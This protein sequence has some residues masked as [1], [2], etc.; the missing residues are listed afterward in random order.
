MSVVAFLPAGLGVTVPEKSNIFYP[1]KIIK[2]IELKEHTRETTLIVLVKKTRS[3]KW[4]NCT[5]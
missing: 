2:I 1:L 5:S 3:N 4:L